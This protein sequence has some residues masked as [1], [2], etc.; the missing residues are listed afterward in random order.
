M[1]ADTS[2]VG[3]GIG[4]YAI[5]DDLSFGGPTDVHDNNVT[6][7]YLNLNK[8]TLIHS[9]RLRLSIIPYQVVLLCN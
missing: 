5:I 7:D 6:V 1:V 3:G 2:D 8:I 4:S 9:T